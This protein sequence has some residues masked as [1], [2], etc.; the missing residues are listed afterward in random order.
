MAGVVGSRQYLFDLW[1]DTVNT[2]ARVQTRADP[3]TVT[4]SRDAWE[5]V[6]HCCAGTSRGAVELK[7]KGPVELVRVDGF[8]S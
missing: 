3:G 4:L 6:C 8:T 5:R 1:G 7:G 2:A